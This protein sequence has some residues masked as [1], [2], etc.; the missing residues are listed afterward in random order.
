MNMTVFQLHMCRGISQTCT[1]FIAP[2]TPIRL[3]P[4]RH[5]H[6]LQTPVQ[7]RL[8]KMFPK[9]K[10]QISLNSHVISA[11]Y[12]NITGQTF[13][14]A[15]ILRTNLTRKSQVQNY[16]IFFSNRMKI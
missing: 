6:S 11:F 12:C 16:D 5:V 8:N 15:F 3:P 14:S 2:S 1:P 7:I 10:Q 9:I 4:S 13:K